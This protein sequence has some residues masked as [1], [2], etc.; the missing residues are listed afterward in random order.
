MDKRDNKNTLLCIL[1]IKFNVSNNK[2]SNI[3]K[4]YSPRKDDLIHE[5]QSPEIVKVTRTNYF[6]ASIKTKKNGSNSIDRDKNHLHNQFN[7]T[8]Q[9][10]TMKKK[11]LHKGDG[12]FSIE[13]LRKEIKTPDVEGSRMSNTF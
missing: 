10:F 9:I 6:D 7:I 5:D 2:E 13:G 3:K 4:K 1:K 12:Q 11:D 8:N